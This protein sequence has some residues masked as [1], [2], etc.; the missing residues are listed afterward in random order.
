M[1]IDN[2]G[3]KRCWVEGRLLGGGDVQYKQFMSLFPL[4]L[5]FTP[6]DPGFGIGLQWQVQV[7]L[8]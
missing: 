6:A 8:Q 1:P 7:Q 4:E 5:S 2:R 3:Q